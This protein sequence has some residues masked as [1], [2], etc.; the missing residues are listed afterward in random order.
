[1]LKMTPLQKAALVGFFVVPALLTLGPS[2]DILSGREW[3]IGLIACFIV[4]ILLTAIMQK[5]AAKKKVASESE[6][7]INDATR[8]RILR[9]IWI[10]KVWIGLLVVSLPFGIVNGVAHRAWL[11]TLVGVGISLLLM[12]IAMQEIRHRRK[13]LNQIHE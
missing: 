13:R 4:L 5:R 7:P 3:A 9:R 11:P 1:M 2:Y 10:S 6:I 12:Y 8:K